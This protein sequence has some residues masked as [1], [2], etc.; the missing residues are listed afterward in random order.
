M[1]EIVKEMVNKF[2]V[3]KLTEGNPCL[4]YPIVHGPTKA[5]LL[6][7]IGSIG[8]L[9]IMSSILVLAI[10][11]NEIEQSRNSIINPFTVPSDEVLN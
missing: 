10:H 1:N 5:S 3:L 2:D 7:M 6:Y 11:S 9:L 4:K 8:C